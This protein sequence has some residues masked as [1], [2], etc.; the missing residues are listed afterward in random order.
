MSAVVMLNPDDRVRVTITV[1]VRV[2]SEGR[3]LR[4]SLQKAD[5]RYPQL[6]ETI[7]T[8]FCCYNQKSRIGDLFQY[9]QYNFHPL[10]MIRRVSFM[11]GTIIRARIHTPKR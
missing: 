11:I 4:V 2:G 9:N 6:E 8:R 1:R 7:L 5:T 10:Q 3:R